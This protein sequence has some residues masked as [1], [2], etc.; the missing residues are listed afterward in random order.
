MKKKLYNILWI[1]DEHE[2]FLG[3]KKEVEFLYGVKLVPYKSLNNGIDEIKKNYPLYDGIILDAKFFENEDDIK[4]SEDTDNVFRAKE[5]LLLLEEKKFEVFVLTG[6]AEAYENNTFKKAFK[7]VYRKGIDEDIEQLFIDVKLAA[8]NHIDTQ[9][10]HEYSRVFEVCTERYI[11]ENAAHD[12]LELLA[13]KENGNNKLNQI[14]KIIEDLFQAFYKYELLPKAFFY[15][16]LATTE[17]SKFLAGQETI[18]AFQDYRIKKESILPTVISNYLKS[19]L[20]AT[21]DGSHRGKTDAHINE[22]KTP[23][24]FKS[25]LFQLLDVLV[26]FK[27]HVDQNPATNNWEVLSDDNQSTNKDDWILGK[28]I[29]YDSYKGFAFLSPANGDKSQFIPPHLVTKYG[30]SNEQKIKGTVEE[31]TDTRSGEQKIRVNKIEII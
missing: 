11:G 9:L 1:D 20:F 25:L 13:H 14:R 28:V 8:D 27:E 3:F 31:Y 5:Q 2:G 22:L 21:H 30:L 17:I 24:L 7:K 4:G 26:W 6:Q 16:R 10:R 19:I 18:D 29:N 23:Y 15:P 12:I